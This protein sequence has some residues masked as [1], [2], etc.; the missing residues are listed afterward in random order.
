M[1]ALFVMV[2]AAILGGRS[3]E[4]EHRRVTDALR[5]CI[6]ALAARYEAA[7]AANVRSG[8]EGLVRELR[9]RIEREFQSHTALCEKA[10]ELAEGLM[11]R[12]SASRDDNI[13]VFLDPLI[14][15]DR[16]AAFLDALQLPW[17]ELQRVAAARGAFRPSC[18]SELVPSRIDTT[19][20]SE[21]VTGLVRGGGVDVSLQRQSSFAWEQDGGVKVL[22]SRLGRRVLLGLSGAGARDQVFWLTPTPVLHLLSNSLGNVSTRQTV[23]PVSMEILACLRVSAPD[24]K[25]T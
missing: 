19:I 4:R 10:T 5:M 15:H 8:V 2:V 23:Q 17:A 25:G 18:G 9:E 24:F 12:V 3:Y 22:V 1:A 13:S 20:L 14:D 7:T 16:A 6:S 11:E 21:Y